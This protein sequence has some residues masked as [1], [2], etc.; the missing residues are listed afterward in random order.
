MSLQGISSLDQSAVQYTKTTE[1]AKQPVK[2]G[3]EKD[4]R[5]AV[6]EKGASDTKIHKPDRQ[7]IERMRAEAEQRHS[8]LRDLV[9]KMFQKQGQAFT[10]ADMY[11]LLRSDNLEVDSETKKKA[12]EDIS[13]DGYY[14]VKETSNRLVS[15]AKAL[16]GED[17][18]KADK[19]I[20]A[21]KKG[22]D[23]ATK[24]WGGELPDICKKTVEE[25]IK[26]LEDWKNK[27]DI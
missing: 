4:T 17:P 16:S 7:T 11:K 24:A 12:L 22:F 9:A 8:Q 19:L 3:T 14:G 18:E 10:D 25:T 13:E 23:A 5:A 6:Y 26:Q 1:A 2:E 27:K 15:F 21:V 20:A